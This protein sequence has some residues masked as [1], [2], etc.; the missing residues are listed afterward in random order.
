MNP[1]AIEGADQSPVAVPLV[2]TSMT[3]D[4]L[5]LGRQHQAAFLK[6]APALAAA[7]RPV[8]PVLDNEEKLDFTPAPEPTRGYAPGGI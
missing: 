3:R 1:E 4:H 6:A 7:R 8:A 2:G 5:S